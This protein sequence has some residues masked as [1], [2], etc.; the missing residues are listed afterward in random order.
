M[1]QILSFY[2][3]D[4][5]GLTSFNKDNSADFSSEKKY[6]EAVPGCLFLSGRKPEVKT[7]TIS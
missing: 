2:D 7:R 1:L 5:E 4:T 6:N 3:R